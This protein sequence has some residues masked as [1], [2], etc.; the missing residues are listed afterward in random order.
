LQD[1]DW[2]GCS[3]LPDAGPGQALFSRKTVQPLF[4]ERVFDQYNLE[5]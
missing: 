3:S 4:A 2:F 5:R 1:H